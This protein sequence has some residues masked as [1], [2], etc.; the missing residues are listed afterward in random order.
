MDQTTIRPAEITTM[1]VA[2]ERIFLISWPMR[3]MKFM[4]NLKS[5]AQSTCW[6][7]LF[8]RI[9]FMSMPRFGYKTLLTL[10]I[11]QFKLI[12]VGRLLQMVLFLFHIIIFNNFLDLTVEELILVTDGCPHQTQNELEDMNTL[13]SNSGDGISARYQFDVFGFTSSAAVHIHC[14][15]EICSVANSFEC[16]RVCSTFL[17]SIK[18]NR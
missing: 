1:Q 3:K 14:A 4:K 17:C 18:T 9:S 12:D 16:R 8:K 13:V 10:K 6:N 15:I 11:L 5:F 7:Y 2:E